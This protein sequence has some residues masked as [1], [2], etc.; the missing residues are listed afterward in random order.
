MVRNF[1]FLAS[2][3]L[4]W[5]IFFVF[6][7][8]LF[9]LYEW[10]LTSI[11]GIVSLCKAFAVGFK[12]DVSMAS[13]MIMITCLLSLL[14]YVNNTVFYK[15]IGIVT[16]FF[17][18]VFILI[19][20]SDLDLYRNWLTHI[21]VTIFQFFDKSFSVMSSTRNDRLIFLIFIWL[22]LSFLFIF[23]FYKIIYKS[24]AK[25]ESRAKWY[26]P[27]L[28]LLFGGI[29]FI[30][31]RGGVDVAAMNSGS[32]YFSTNMT[33]NHVAVNPVW[34]F[35]YSFGKRSVLKNPYVF[36]DSK[37]AMKI[38]SDFCPQQD[39]TISVLNT[40]KPNVVI[41]LMESFESDITETL[42]GRKGITPRFDSLTHEGILFS[43]MIASGTRTDKG[44][45]SVLSGYPAQSVNPIIKF[46]RK[47]EKLPTISK[48][49]SDRGY[50]LMFVYGGNKQFTNM[51]SLITVGGFQDV[52]DMN[53]FKSEFHTFKWGVHDSYVFERSIEKMNQSRKPFCTFIMTL[54]NHEP[55]EVPT[56]NKFPGENDDSHFFTSAYYADSCLGAFVDMA[57]KQTW[58]NN[59]LIIFV[60]DHA[61][62]YPCNKSYENIKRYRIPMLWL[63]GA[64]KVKDTIVS[65]YCSQMDIP[66]T[67]LHQMD[68]S[69][70]KFSFSQNIFNVKN[71][72]SALFCYN[73][74]FGLISDSFFQIYDNSLRKY[75]VYK[76][77]FQNDDS[78]IGKAF[79][80]IVNEDFVQ[81]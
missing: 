32:V 52:T 24:F 55:F 72:G 8:M 48:E 19:I 66:S 76:G 59:T 60:A 28:C 67:I 79:W 63:G 37:K 17:T 61:A 68:V 39:S 65:K 25:N 15:T 31:A 42:G 56:N 47:I 57:K 2:L 16:G 71:K 51:N 54:S 77:S 30:P 3:F 49:L 18:T 27:L 4:F 64:L 62:I 73:D 21:D 45:V 44:F 35:L 75:S 46:T 14:Q 70:T 10:H 53:D 7:K 50:N 34:N 9:V 74:G 29:M 38:Y 22:I 11:I 6:G 12:M 20:V 26:Q 36:M 33:S 23:S 81:K 43:N 69:C 40:Q 41:V 80:Q 58:W 13:Y 5:I 78:L 1:T